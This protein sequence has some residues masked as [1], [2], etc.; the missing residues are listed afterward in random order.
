[1]I[2]LTETQ[3]DQIKA[4]GIAAYP[5]E[6][7]GLLIGRQLAGDTIA[8]TRIQPSPDGYGGLGNDRFEIDPQIRIDVERELRGTAER[9]IGHY[10]SHPD[11]PAMPSQTDLEMAFE[12]DLIW[13]IVSIK[14]GA[15]GDIKAHQLDETQQK[16]AEIPI[17]MI[18]T[19]P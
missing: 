13:L 5:A 2:R 12:P 9:V 18:K 8:V 6:C 17:S 19:T 3:I 1:M 14:D 16:F 15:A 11:H 7:C 4:A 10:H